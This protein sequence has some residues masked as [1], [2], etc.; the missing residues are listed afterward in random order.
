MKKPPTGAGRQ[1]VVGAKQNSQSPKSNSTYPP[2]PQ[3]D[4]P[5]DFDPDLN[6][7]LARHWFGVHPHGVTSLWWRFAGLGHRLPAELGVIVIEGGR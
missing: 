3:A 7:I 4:V 2:S 5:I 6:P 1:A